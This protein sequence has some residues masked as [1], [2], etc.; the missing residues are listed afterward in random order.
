MAHQFATTASQPQRTRIEKGVVSLLS[1]LKKANG[2]YLV[3]VK[4]FAF[5]LK[6]TTTG[7]DVAQFVAEMSR[8]PS[9]AVHT[10]DRDERVKTIGG[11]A[12]ESEIDLLVYFSS[13][14]ARNQQVGRME[15]DSAGLA[16]N[17]A[18]PGIHI[19][20]EHA[21]ELLLGQRVD[22][23]QD[24]KQV[25]CHREEEIVSAQPITIWLQTYKVTVLTQLDQFRTVTQLLDSIRFRAAGD[26]AEVHLPAAKTKSNT[27]DVN[28]DDL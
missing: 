7:D 27:V 25:R 21:K 9:I 19:A 8:A 23:G 20:M 15:I 26:P 1:G 2:G 22:S 17:S 13:N 4:P 11:F 12:Y 28:V 18:D 6:P 14:N 10:G 5:T 3:E 16:S 24:I